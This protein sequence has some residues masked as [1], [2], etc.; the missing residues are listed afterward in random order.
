MG[1]GIELI[2]K[3]RKRQ[4]NDEGWSAEHDLQH[5]SNELAMAAACY[6]L[7]KEEV[8]VL[9]SQMGEP[10]EIF[11]PWPWFS[12]YYRYSDNAPGYIKTHDKRDTHDRIKKLTISGALIAAELD[13]LLST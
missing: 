11:D 1:T 3:E 2:A 10:P 8:F 9:K 5:T 7:D 4:I 13:R 6:A 12:K